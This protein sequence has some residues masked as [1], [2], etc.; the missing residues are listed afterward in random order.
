M[1]QRRRVVQVGLGPIG[2]GTVK[3]AAER[4]DVAVV[5]AV[6]IRREL[7]GRQVSDVAGIMAAGSVV[8]SVATALERF[9]PH[10]ALVTTV[11]DLAEVVEE[12]EIL[13]RAGVA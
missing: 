2:I 3:M 4:R 5:G 6:D 9:S 11:S 13:L 1:K 8:A 10:V 12:C 7:E